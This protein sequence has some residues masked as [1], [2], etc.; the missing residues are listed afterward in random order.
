[1]TP[2][3]AALVAIAVGGAVGA[4]ARAG[5]GE[6]LPAGRWPWATLVANIAGTLLLAALAALIALRPHLP[7]WLH[8]LVAVGFCGSLTTFSAI[9]VES[10]L[11][12]REGMSTDAV[13]YVAASVVL[14][15][16]AAVAARRAV[17]AVHA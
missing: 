17:Q 6:A 9:Q 10:V 16:I 14:G 2:R 1:M 4:L 8:P 5:L 13:L 3:T 12:M 11:M 7:H 15:L